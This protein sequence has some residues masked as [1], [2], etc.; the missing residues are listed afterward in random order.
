MEQKLQ[1]NK[2]HLDSLINLLVNLYEQGVD[3]IDMLSIKQD[4]KDIL[5][6]NVREEYMIEEAREE[7]PLSDEDL[8]KLIG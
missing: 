1:I 6:V 8:N 7:K 2:V 4:G 3:Y 5:Q